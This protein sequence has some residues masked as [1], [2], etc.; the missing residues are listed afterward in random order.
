MSQDN[1]IL[2]KFVFLSSFILFLKIL[3]FKKLLL[4][5]L[6]HLI[7]IKNMLS[8]YQLRKKNSKE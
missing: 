1:K 5:I 4:F 3:S 7:I 6:A 2:L 8:E